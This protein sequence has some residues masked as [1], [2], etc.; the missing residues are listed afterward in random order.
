VVLVGF[1]G[2]GKSAVGRALARLL[3][4]R[5]LDT[6]QWVA[7]EAAMP[8][9]TLFADFGEQA[10]RDLETA[11]ARE[12]GR[13]R[14]LIVATGGGIMGRDENLELL[15]RGG[16]LICLR[17]RPEVILARTAPWESRPLLRGA[18]DPAAAVERLLAEREPR[19]ALADWSVDT[20][21]LE[22][23]AVAEVICAKLPSLFRDWST[24]SASAR[25]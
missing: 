13:P 1:M 23:P 15:R 19:Y 7:A 8:I 10:F 5:L 6:D 22:P 11:A 20:S 16:V 12:A 25:A 9:P 14:G 3:K 4:R 24:R 18:A 17:A 2:T 21:D